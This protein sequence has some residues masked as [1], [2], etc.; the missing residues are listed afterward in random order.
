MKTDWLK[1]QRR[2]LAVAC[3]C[4]MLT[5][6]A[7]CTD[8]FDT[9]EP[10]GRMT[11]RL[12][13]ASLDEQT[14]NG[15]DIRSLSGHVDT[16]AVNDDI[17]EN[18]LAHLWVL[19]FNGTGDDASFVD[20]TE[21]SGENLRPNDQILGNLQVGENQH[22]VF[23]ANA[24]SLISSAGFTT[25]KTLADFK[26]LMQ[27]V[28]D[29]KNL[30][31]TTIRTI[32]MVGY[33]SGTIVDRQDGSSPISA[34]IQME[35]VIA[36]VS[37]KVQLG[38]PPSENFKLS[39][40]RL[41]NVPNKIYLSKPT[42][43]TYPAL[44]DVAFA[45]YGDSR[46]GEVSSTTAFSAVWY[47]P[48]NCR[49][50]GT[51]TLSSD[52]TAE[53]LNNVVAG[54]GDKATWVEIIGDYTVGNTTYAATYTSYIGGNSTTDYN[55][56][57]NSHYDITITIRGRN[58]SDSRVKLYGD[59]STTVVNPDPVDNNPN[60]LPI[61]S[62]VRDIRQIGMKKVSVSAILTL[63]GEASNRGFLYSSTI[64]TELGLVK[65]SSGVTEVSDASA[66]AG[67]YTSTLTGLTPGTTYYVRAVATNKNEQ[68][69]YGPIATYKTLAVEPAANCF[70]VEPGRSV[71]FELKDAAGTAKTVDAVSLKWQTKDDGTAAG[72][73]PV[74][75]GN[76]IYDEE[77]GVIIVHTNPAARAG[78]VLITGAL[79][80]SDIWAWHLWITPYKPTGFSI[81]GANLY[82][83]VQQGRVMTFGPQYIV[84]TGGNVIMDRDLGSQSTSTL[85]TFA[86]INAST[87]LLFGLYYLGDYYMP[88][89]SSQRTNSTTR[90]PV[91]DIDG[92]P[93]TQP[94]VSRPASVAVGAWKAAGN[95][96]PNG[97]KVP[98]SENVFA[99]LFDI[100]VIS[101]NTSSSY[102]KGWSYIQ[103]GVNAY[104][105]ASGMLASNGTVS[106]FGTTGY[107]WIASGGETNMKA[108]Y[109]NSAA[110]P[111][112][113]TRDYPVGEGRP[114]RCIKNNDK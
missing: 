68:T 109:Y 3:G 31:D 63:D 22:L 76:L 62:A 37:L 87:D 12:V 17:K 58:T 16:K 84:A 85:M 98:D 18:D 36:K 56:R 5:G 49:G 20:K 14:A 74:L 94:T 79:N 2:W 53:N 106:G 25:S 10:Q 48:E 92:Q 57:R 67:S 38:L 40:V 51:A 83:E 27:T 81:N 26:K 21:Y 65:G 50:T 64:N 73:L 59:A 107:T 60:A 34:T 7:G 97:W 8:G 4:L 45:N 1:Q 77:N 82:E 42:T 95:P 89:P 91:Y 47:M 99:D 90:V 44:T 33:W 24:K 19:Q 108:L 71:M 28:T 41:H 61:L 101:Y 52:K 72:Q 78:N 110:D 54:S 111:K 105:L 15:S 75:Q 113:A 103:G 30:F 96:C 100:G 80:G 35:R 29:E 43:D 32:P 66:S 70:M 9:L 55:L 46:K 11:L 88:F 6:L 102:Y 13:A 114:I 93:A 104:F 23:V 69:S 39:S 86:Q 112:L